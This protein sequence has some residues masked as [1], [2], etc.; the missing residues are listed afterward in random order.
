MPMIVQSLH[1]ADSVSN[2]KQIQIK[3]ACNEMKQD[4]WKGERKRAIKRKK[5]SED[6]KNTAFYAFTHMLVVESD[7]CYS[8]H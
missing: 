1:A 5:T 3:C 8:S 7:G 2:M 4:E 6:R